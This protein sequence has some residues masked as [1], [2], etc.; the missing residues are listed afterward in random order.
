MEFW[1]PPDKNAISFCVFCIYRL[2]QPHMQLLARTLIYALPLLSLSACG[3]MEPAQQPQK[4]HA[5]RKQNVD[6]SEYIAALAQWQLGQWNKADIAAQRAHVKTLDQY[7]QSHKKAKKPQRLTLLVMDYSAPAGGR[8]Q[9]VLPA[10]IGDARAD[11]PALNKLAP[12]LSGI[13]YTLQNI[14]A[15]RASIIPATAA[16]FGKEEEWPAQAD[17]LRT[18]LL[19]NATPLA[20]AD[21]ARLQ[22]EV[23]HISLGRRLRDAAYI[24]LENAKQAVARLEAVSPEKAA[25]L[26]KDVTALEEALHRDMPYEL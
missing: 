20:D 19:A 18:R 15:V 11:I 17:A 13:P 6:E 7:A 23:A 12:A 2:C 4:T 21:N 14:H 3:M 22:L 8:Q 9:L 26:L 1:E 25:P 5:L 10:S 16:V 24:A